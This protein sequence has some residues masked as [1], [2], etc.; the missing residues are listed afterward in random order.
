VRDGLSRKD[1]T[2]PENYTQPL[3]DGPSK[4]LCVTREELDRMLND[5]YGRRGWDQEGRPTRRT[6][7]GLGLSPSIHKFDN[8]FIQTLAE[9]IRGPQ[10]LVLPS[11]MR[12]VDELMSSRSSRME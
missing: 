8:E 3:L 4:G 1:D 9:L 2:L 5:Y 11:A 6:L 12:H 10:D 7:V